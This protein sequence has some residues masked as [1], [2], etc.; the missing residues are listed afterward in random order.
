MSELPSLARTEKIL[1]EDEVREPSKLLAKSAGAEKR[2][3]PSRVRRLCVAS[4]MV[5]M[6]V[7]LG[8]GAV[9]FAYDEV[10][11]NS[12]SLYVTTTIGEHHLSSRAGGRDLGF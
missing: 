6:V 9:V 2:L 5:S 11:S 4:L 8:L 1:V 3:R 7:G 10:P 12:S